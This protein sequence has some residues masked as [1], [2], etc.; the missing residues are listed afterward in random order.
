[1]WFLYHRA[2]SGKLS[3]ESKCGTPVMALDCSI[4][5]CEGGAKVNEFTSPVC[6]CAWA[7]DSQCCAVCALYF[8]AHPTSPTRVSYWGSSEIGGAYSS[9]V[10]LMRHGWVGESNWGCQVWLKKWCDQYKCI[11]LLV[12]WW[13]HR[14]LQRS[15]QSFMIHKVDHSLCLLEWAMTGHL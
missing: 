14:F 3:Q 6:F 15:K 10:L 5:L 13:L 7:S 12:T 8:E 2:S 4:C 9:D 11:I 1:M